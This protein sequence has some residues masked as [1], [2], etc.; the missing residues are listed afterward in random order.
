MNLDQARLQLLCV[1]ATPLWTGTVD[2]YNVDGFELTVTTVSG[3]F[4]TDIANLLIVHNGSELA[5]IKSRA[6]QVL[7]LAENPVQFLQTLPVAIYNARLPWTRYQRINDGVVYKDYDIAF[8]ATWQAEL[9]PTALIKARVSSNPWGEA[10]YAATGETIYLDASASYANLATGAPL[11]YTWAPGS[12]GA[13]TGSGAMVTCV[14]STTGFRYLKLIVTDAHGT[15]SAR[16]LPVWIG[17][18]QVFSAVTRCDARW[19]ARQGWTVDLELHGAEAVLQYSPALLIDMATREALF[20]GFIVPNSHTQ[21]FETTTRAVTLQSALAFSRYL[22]AYPFLVTGLTGAETPDNWA[23][24]YGL[25]LAR[26][27]WFLLFWHSVLPEIVNCDLSLA[28]TRAISGQEFTLGNLVQQIEAV[29]KSAFWQARG[30]RTG[31]FVVATDPLYLDSADWAALSGVDLSAATALREAIEMQY[32]QP[33]V[34]QVRVGGVYRGSGGSFQPALAQAPAYPAA[35]GNPTEVNGLAPANETELHLWARRYIA[36]ENYAA[37]YSARPGVDVDPATTLV[38]DLPGGVRVAIERAQLNFDPRALRWQASLEGRTYG[39]SVSAVSVPLPPPI[40]YPPPSTPP[41]LP[42]IWDPLP[43][44]VWGDGNRGDG[45]IVV[46]AANEYQSEEGY[47][48]RTF[49]FRAASPTWENIT[50]TSWTFATAFGLTMPITVVDV[51]IN[52]VTKSVWVEIRG[53]NNWFGV[54][55][56]RDALDQGVAVPAWNL[57]MPQGSLSP[58][59]LTFVR[60]EFRAI[61]RHP[62]LMFDTTLTVGPY[63]FVRMC[64]AYPDGSVKLSESLFMARFNDS[65]IVSQATAIGKDGGDSLACT[66]DWNDDITGFRSIGR[67]GGKNYRCNVPFGTPLSEVTNFFAPNV[68]PNTLYRPLLRAKP[69]Y[70]VTGNNAKTEGWYISENSLWNG[71]DDHSVVLNFNRVDLG[72]DST[73]QSE[74]PYARNIGEREGWLAI[75]AG[76]QVNNA[77][78]WRSLDGGATWNTLSNSTIPYYVTVLVHVKPGFYPGEA[79][80]YALFQT[81]RTK[82]NPGPWQGKIFMYDLDGLQLLEKTGNLESLVSDARWGT[83]PFSMGV[84]DT[85][86]GME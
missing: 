74:Q 30:R 24:V 53:A 33:N 63:M 28:P 5:R 7:T 62:R 79:P 75:Y 49:N 60:A 41:L 26:A 21:T 55:Y 71:I 20:F 42:P 61:W 36:A 70:S 29:L 47:I 16:Y 82:S 35:W 2:T 65:G 6:G 9:P 25:T 37:Q 11:S 3:A 56:S 13:I 32:A 57:L 76:T 23:E 52:Q 48:F 64:E 45:N 78:L 84:F 86:W 39:P 34:S 44:E 18:A 15:S 50:P 14:Y 31:G 80:Y 10:V 67:T 4:P 58:T 46:F 43:E 54:I 22:Y 8:P 59:P 85:W 73:S 81:Y 72:V 83:Y 69:G 77:T 1:P 51:K 40:V 12:G 38:A 27:A 17:D 66:V 19:D 68:R